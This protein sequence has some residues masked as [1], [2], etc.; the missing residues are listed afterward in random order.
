MKTA[1]RFITAIFLATLI[2]PFAAFA[3]VQNVPPPLPPADGAKDVFQQALYIR[4][5][6]TTVV[7]EGGHVSKDKKDVLLVEAVFD[8]QEGSMEQMEADYTPFIDKLPKGS[9]MEKRFRALLKAGVT[10]AGG[11]GKNPPNAG[12]GSQQRPAAQQGQQPRQ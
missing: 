10:G 11:D 1:I 3:Q 7:I 8:A 2:L 5:G 6:K 12:S 4:D 9:L